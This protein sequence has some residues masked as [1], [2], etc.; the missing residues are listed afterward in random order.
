[1]SQKKTQDTPK[2]EASKFDIRIMTLE[3]DD[4]LLAYATANIPG[5]F[6]IRGIKVLNGANGMFVSMPQYKTKN[7]EYKDV[8]FFHTKEASAEFDKAV[9][10]AYFQTLSMEQKAAG[11]QGHAMAG[12]TG[13]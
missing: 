8:C 10:S 12:M 1:M 5:D 13:M 3:R 6:A 9:I 7:D 2:Q 4:N 11:E